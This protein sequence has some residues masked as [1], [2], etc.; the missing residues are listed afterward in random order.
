MTFQLILYGESHIGYDFTVAGGLVEGPGLPD[1]PDTGAG[2]TAQ[3]TH[4][5][6]GIVAFT[7]ALL[8][9]GACAGRRRVRQLN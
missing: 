6:R 3:D 5:G 1:V 8:L 9:A 4:S 2:G 7:A